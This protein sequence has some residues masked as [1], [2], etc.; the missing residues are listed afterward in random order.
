MNVWKFDSDV[1]VDVES[2]WMKCKNTNTVHSIWA[3]W[4][5]HVL[6]TESISRASQGN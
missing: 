4:T 2:Y 1:A 6:M 3:E 5:D